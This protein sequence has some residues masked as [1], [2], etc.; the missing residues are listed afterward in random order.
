MQFQPPTFH[1]Q[2]HDK[3]RSTDWLSQWGGQPAPQTAKPIG[4]KH[5][6]H[7]RSGN[8]ATQCFVKVES[9]RWWK[10]CR[11]QWIP[12]PFIQIDKAGDYIDSKSS[13]M[14]VI[15]M[16]GK[17]PQRSRLAHILIELIVKMNMYRQLTS[18]WWAITSPM[19]PFWPGGEGGHVTEGILYHYNMQTHLI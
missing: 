17:W 13:I 7:S 12:E 3:T 15:S 2:H 6:I 8:M 5:S 9:D 18:L 14:G 11:F 16:Y 19:W 10:V 1:H 4:S